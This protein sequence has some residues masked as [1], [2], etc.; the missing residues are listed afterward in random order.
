MTRQVGI[1]VN[2]LKM[3]GFQNSSSTVQSLELSF[4]ETTDTLRLERFKKLKV[5]FSSNRFHVETT[6]TK[7]SSSKHFS[8]MS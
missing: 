4:S 8:D 3:S 7:F 5:Y 6:Y 2:F 1:I